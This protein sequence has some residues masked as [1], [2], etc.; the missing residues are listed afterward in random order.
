MPKFL[1]QTPKCQAMGWESGVGRGGRIRNP[2]VQVLWGSLGRCGQSM[3]TQQG[4]REA[5]DDYA[6]AQK[7][8]FTAKGSVVKQIQETVS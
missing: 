5:E 1:L 7:G 2:H 6:S 3:T 8:V 4:D